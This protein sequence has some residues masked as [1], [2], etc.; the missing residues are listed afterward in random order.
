[1]SLSSIE[2]IRD[3]CLHLEKLSLHDVEFCG[4]KEES[5][6]VVICARF[7]EVISGG[8]SSLHT[9]ELLCCS[10]THVD[11]LM[12]WA[13]HLA[14]Q[15]S[16]QMPTLPSLEV[17]VIAKSTDFIDSAHGKG[18]AAQWQDGQYAQL[19][20]LL[21]DECGIALTVYA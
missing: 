12:L 14:Q 2:L 11:A 15:R 16:M 18:K 1:V 9:L 6:T 5:N 20:K 19:G 8:F 13:R 10:W 4:E 7:L 3:S 17:L 21:Q